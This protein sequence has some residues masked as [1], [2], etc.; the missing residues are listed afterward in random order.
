VVYSITPLVAANHH[1]SPNRAQT[2][3]RRR[4]STR[5]SRNQ[6]YETP[7]VGTDNATAI[8]DAKFPAATHSP[9]SNVLLL[10]DLQKQPASSLYIIVYN[11]VYIII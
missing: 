10:I 8:S 2:K 3:V 4:E 6:N 9:T 11:L 7:A 1:F 5:E